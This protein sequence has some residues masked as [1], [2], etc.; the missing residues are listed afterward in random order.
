MA[1]IGGAA[2]LVFP[3]RWYENFPVTIVEAFARGLP[4]VA[5][6][7]GAV[8]EIVADGRTGML[9]EAGDA[10]DLGEKLACAASSPGTLQ[11]MGAAARA[12]YVCKYGGERNYELLID[13]Y[14]RALEMGRQP[15]MNPTE[16]RF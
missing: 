4:V 6:N 9:F 11:W 8:P 10:D 14:E 1:E 15:E 12:E 3:S 5:S 2:C 16:A 7:L 13:V